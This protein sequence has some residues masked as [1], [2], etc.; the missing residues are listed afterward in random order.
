MVTLSWLEP[1][2]EEVMCDNCSERFARGEAQGDGYPKIVPKIDMQS[3]KT[4]KPSTVDFYC[5]KSCD[6]D[7]EANYLK[8]EDD[9]G[10]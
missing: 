8:R 1:A 3:N 7:P 10:E 2:D 4:D 6:P 5:S 9:A